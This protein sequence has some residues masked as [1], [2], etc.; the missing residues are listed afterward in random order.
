MCTKADNNAMHLTKLIKTIDTIRRYHRSDSPYGAYIADPHTAVG[1]CAASHYL[2]TH[3]E[4]AN[5]TASSHSGL[6]QIIL[7]TAH[8]AKFSSA[9][10]EALSEN[11]TFDFNRDVLPDE[12]KGLLEKERRVIE[13]KGT[14]P[15]LTKKV[16]KEQVKKLFG[17]IVG[18]D[19]KSQAENTTSV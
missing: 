12:F 8:P 9:V 3:K 16:V 19:G 18:K 13:V 4:E 17:N 2:S 10:E 1:L 6:I 7:S 11:A 5:G 14:D 15:E